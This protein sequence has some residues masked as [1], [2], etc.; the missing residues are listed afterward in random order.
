M[1]LQARKSSK[2]NR[3]LQPSQKC[4]RFEFLSKKTAQMGH[5]WTQWLLFTLSCSLTRRNIFTNILH[6]FNITMYIVIKRL[7]VEQRKWRNGQIPNKLSFWRG[8]AQSP[9]LNPIKNLWQK[10]GRQISK[11]KPTSK[12]EL[13]E[14]IIEAWHHIV[15]L[16]Q[17]R[18]LVYSMPWRYRAVLRNKS[19]PTKY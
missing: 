8:P 1:W 17:T 5:S 6:A 16:E 14:K 3:Y 9:D 19:W 4:C 2:V 13:I 7:Q 12:R 18:K 11:C 15:T 10:V